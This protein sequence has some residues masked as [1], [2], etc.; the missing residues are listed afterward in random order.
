MKNCVA[1]IKLSKK[2]DSLPCVRSLLCLGTVQGASAYIFTIIKILKEE[3]KK[4]Y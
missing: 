4:N 3:L 2:K 1:I